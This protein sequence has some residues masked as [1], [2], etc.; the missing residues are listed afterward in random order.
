MLNFY[1]CLPCNINY[2][3]YLQI[4]D[5]NTI[6]HG[7]SPSINIE[8]VEINMDGE[9]LYEDL[10]CQYCGEEF[11]IMKY[12][13]NHI[14]SEHQRQTTELNVKGTMKEKVVNRLDKEGVLVSIPSFSCNNCEK[15]YQIKR[16][17]QD[18]KRYKHGPCATCSLCSKVFEGKMQLGNHVRDHHS[19]KLL[20]C[21][22][23]GKRFTRKIDHQKHLVVC[24]KGKCRKSTGQD[25]NFTCEMCSKG[26]A[27]KDGLVQHVRK[28]HKFELL[29][30]PTAFKSE[31]F[32]KYFTRSRRGKREA[33][34]NCTKCSQN[35]KKRSNL[36]RHML[37][38]KSYAVP[39][40]GIAEA[41]DPQN[42][43]CKACAKEFGSE[44][45][46]W[47]HIKLVHPN[48]NPNFKCDQCA[49]EFSSKKSMKQH[50]SRMH[51]DTVFV[52]P[53]CLAEF[54]QNYN[55]RTHM[56]TCK[57]RVVTLE[58]EFES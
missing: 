43:V 35:F 47:S 56:K 37:V 34:W 40:T 7:E 53:L 11:P 14:T 10:Q 36:K 17:L 22:L 24:A 5:H 27:F 13:V 49:K 21:A 16:A 33:P 57:W 29:N 38:H 32:D 51:N 58:Q 30:Q 18:H 23:C 4:V 19:P 25:P 42:F 48:P 55:K 15:S 52:C 6:V 2:E 54:S 12:L 45:V 8:M 20:S 50:G 28:M 44:N 3:S 46:L 31:I 1:P 39:R 41:E 9:Q 26:F